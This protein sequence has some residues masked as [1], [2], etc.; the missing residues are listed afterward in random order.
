MATDPTR[1]AYLKVQEVME[2]LRISRS[3]Y[4]C[5]IE[6]GKLRAVRINSSLRVHRDEVARITRDY[7]EG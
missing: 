4:Y 6:Q 2:A 7:F 3:T 1:H 5:W